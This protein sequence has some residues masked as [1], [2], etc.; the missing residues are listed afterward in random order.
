MIR[1][2][3]VQI[4]ASNYKNKFLDKKK[5]KYGIWSNRINIILFN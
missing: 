4:T 3:V 1:K 2:D 5:P